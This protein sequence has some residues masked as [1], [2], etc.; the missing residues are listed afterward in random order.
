M[1]STVVMASEKSV[2]AGSK[3]GGRDE[4]AAA[5]QQ[6]LPESR[7]HACAPV[8]LR[9]QR[10]AAP[11]MIFKD[12]VRDQ[13]RLVLRGEGVLVEAR[14]RRLLARQEIQRQD[15]RM[16][17]GELRRGHHLLAGEGSDDEVGAL[18][19]RA[20]EA[21][22][23]A[24]GARVVDAHA[25][26]LGERRLVVG[27]EEAIAHADRRARSAPRDRQQQREVWRRLLGRDHRRGSA[28]GGMP[29]VRAARVRNSA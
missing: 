20:A 11:V 29:A 17:A 25:R 12:T 16:R 4:L 26:P 7:Q 21:L 6:L 8:P 5:G 14:R 18:L 15:R 3:V 27:G 23:H 13:A 22:G 24:G 10:H 9:Q 28:R 19:G 2:R 1:P